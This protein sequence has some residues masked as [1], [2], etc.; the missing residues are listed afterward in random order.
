MDLSKLK[1]AISNMELVEDRLIQKL[2]SSTTGAQ[3]HI[4][5]MTQCQT[6]LVALKKM[7]PT[8]APKMASKSKSKDDNQEG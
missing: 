6:D 2:S 3:A 4:G 5:L 1:R 7:L 8:E